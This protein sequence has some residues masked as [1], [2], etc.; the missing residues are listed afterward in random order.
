ME[1]PPPRVSL[2]LARFVIGS[3]IG[4]ATWLMTILQHVPSRPALMLGVAGFFVGGA[5]A[6]TS[7]RRSLNAAVGFGLAFVIGNQGRILF[8]GA[9]PLVSLFTIASVIGL[10]ASGFRRWSLAGGVAG[11]V[12]GAGMTAVLVVRL[13]N[14]HL[15]SGST[16][17][18]A[19]GWALS[20]TLPWI[21]G[22][23]AAA[24]VLREDSTLSPKSP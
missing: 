12:V 8:P 14:A 17:R 10:V 13:A 18:V 19:T 1:P 16:S 3:A 7:L 4:A 6:G 9:A 2:V 11:F 20:L 22:G 23:L 5:V 21:F 15:T 24:A